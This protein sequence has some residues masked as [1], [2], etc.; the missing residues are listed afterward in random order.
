MSIYSRWS[1]VI[2]IIFSAINRSFKI[3]KIISYK[4]IIRKVHVALTQKAYLLSSSCFILSVNQKS[5]PNL[6]GI[7]PTNPFS[8]LKTTQTY[9]L[10]Q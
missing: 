10:K 5:I 2:C 7:L 4:K 1:T 6:F 9:R 8:N 3:I